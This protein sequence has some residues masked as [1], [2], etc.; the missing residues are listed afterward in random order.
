MARA[1]HGRLRGRCRA[2]WPRGSEGARGAVGFAVGLAFAWPRLGGTTLLPLGSRSGRTVAFARVA[3]RLEVPSAT[4]QLSGLALAQAAWNVSELEAGAT[5]CPLA[6]L[7]RGENLQ[8]MRFEADSQDVAIRGGRAELAKQQSTLDAWAFAREGLIDGRAF[9]VGEVRS[10]EKGKLD[11]I[12]VDAWSHE[13]EEAVTVIQAYQPSSSGRFRVL[14][15]A[16]IVAKG[17]TVEGAKADRMRRQ[18]YAGV[19]KHEKV[20][21]VWETWR[22]EAD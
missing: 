6:F 20:A 22:G 13:M 12:A 5:L 7:R 10:S 4:L 16:M 15:E 1:S 18:V 14:G 2:E 3:K 11:V 19:K 9:E 21:P 17:E 8:L